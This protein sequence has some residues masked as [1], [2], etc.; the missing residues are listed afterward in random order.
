MNRWTCRQ[1]ERRSKRL[2]DE[3]GEGKQTNERKDVDQQTDRQT[4]V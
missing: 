1:T 3:Q 2:K 4:D